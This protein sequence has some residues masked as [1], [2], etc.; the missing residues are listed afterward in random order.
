[1]TRIG[2]LLSW[3]AVMLVGRWNW[4]PP[5]WISFSADR[6]RRGWRYLAARPSRAGALVAAVAAVAGG[7]AWYATRPKPH[8]VTVSVAPPGLTEYNDKG[9]SSI[10]PLTL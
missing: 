3:L 7:I 9:I 10:K 2:Q 1:M 6:T 4:Q 5:A 8:Y